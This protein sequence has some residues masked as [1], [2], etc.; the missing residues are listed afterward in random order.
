MQKDFFD[1]LMEE[2]RKLKENKQETT[3]PVPPSPHEVFSIVAEVAKKHNI[4]AEE[5]GMLAAMRPIS[6]TEL[7]IICQSEDNKQ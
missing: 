4:T 3:L 1:E 2:L 7:D 6:K 5:M